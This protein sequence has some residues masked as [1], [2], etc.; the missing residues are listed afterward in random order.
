MMGLLDWLRGNRLAKPDQRLA[1]IEHYPADEKRLLLRVAA[2]IRA[3]RGKPMQEHLAVTIGLGSAVIAL[4]RNYGMDV[5][6][7][8]CPV[9][10][11]I[12]GYTSDATNEQR[13]RATSSL[14]IS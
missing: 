14:T 4:R 2:E 13:T 8:N 3:A 9:E 12:S 5:V 10:Q 1:P 7:P 11:I 6:E